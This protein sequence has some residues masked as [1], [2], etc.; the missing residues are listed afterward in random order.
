MNPSAHTFRSQRTGLRANYPCG[1]IMS[2]STPR[3][4]SALGHG[5]LGLDLEYVYGITETRAP[6]FLVSRLEALFR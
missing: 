3:R 5:R 6:G 1:S 4:Q 2:S